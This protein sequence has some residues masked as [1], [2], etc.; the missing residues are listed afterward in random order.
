MKKTFVFLLSLLTLVSCYDDGALREQMQ[1][2]E[3]RLADLEG[4][5]ISSINDQIAGI[6]ESID[7]LRN[8]DSKLK[9]YIDDLEDLAGEL[10]DRIASAEA[11]V[12][13]LE[14]D[15]ASVI[16]AI[17]EL[18]AYDRSLDDK[19][20]LLQ[21]YVDESLKASKDWAAATFA[22]LE[23]YESVQG[24]LAELRESLGR[25][26][27]GVESLESEFLQELADAISASESGMKTW[28]NE[29]LAGSYYDITEVDARLSALEAAYKD[30]DAS[31]KE[32][33]AAQQKALEQ[34]REELSAEFEKAI[35]DAIRSNEGVL[36]SKIADAV[37]TAQEALQEQ[38]DAI[39]VV[40]ASLEERLAIL[41]SD[42]VG[43]IQSLAYVPEYTDGKV[44]VAEGDGV[45]S[46]K[47]LVAPSRLASSL[48]TLWETDGKVIT[49]GLCYSKNPAT[50][51]ASKELVPLKV[52]S[53]TATSEG[54][55]HLTISVDEENPLS[56]DF[57]EGKISALAYIHITD[58]NND[59][60]SGMIVLEGRKGSA[61]PDH[62]ELPIPGPG[63]PSGVSMTANSYIISEA[64]SY[65]IRT[66]KGNSTESVG[67]VASAEVLWESFGTDEAPEAGDLIASVS[68]FNGRIG[69][70]TGETFRE[71]NAVIAAKDSDGNI[72]W[73][74]HIWMT[75]QP[76]E[77][78]YYNGAGT[79]MDRNLG[80]TSAT[81]G[82][83]GALGLLY[84]WGRKDPFL[85]SSSISEAVEAASTLTWPS[86]VAS[87][88]STG[89]IEYAAAN[90]MTFITNGSGNYD[91]YYTG[92]TT[93]DNTRWAESVSS[94]TMFD[95]CPVGWRVPDGGESGVWSSAKGSSSGFTHTYDSVNEGMNFSGQF[96]AVQAIWYPSSG[97]VSGSDGNRYG[98]G[99]WSV[100]WSSSCVSSYADGL[101]FTNAGSVGTFGNR[102]SRAFGYPVRCM[103]EGS[104]TGS[105]SGDSDNP[106]G[107]EGG[108]GS[109]GSNVDIGT[110]ED[111][112]S[113]L[114][115]ANSYIVTRSG[116]YKFKAYKGNSQDL[117]G[118][119]S[120]VDPVG[121]IAKAEVLW[122]S[123]GTSETPEAGA[124]ITDVAY[125]YPYIGFK[126]ADTFREGNAVIAVKDAS[127]NILWSWHIWM[128]DYPVEQVYYNGA[129][130]M[131]DRNLGSTSATPGDVGALGLLY[132]WGRKDPVLGSSSISEAVVAASTITWPS[133]VASDASTGTIEYAA[134][135]PTTFIFNQG[136]NY[137]WYYTGDITTDGTR[138]VESN[139]SKTIYDP[140]PVGWRVPDGGE[141]GV[142]RVGVGPL[143][144]GFPIESLSLYDSRNIGINF[145]NSLGQEQVIWY[146]LTSNRAHYNGVLRF[147]FWG[148]SWSSSFYSDICEYDCFGFTDEYLWTNLD[149]CGSYGLSVRCMKEGSRSSAPSTPD[150]T[151][152]PT[153]DSDPDTLIDYVDEY[154][155][156]HGVGVKI[157]E[158]V[159]APVN[160]GYH[161]T[162]FKY[163]KLYQWGRKYGQGYSGYYYA[164]QYVEAPDSDSV[165]PEIVTG[166]V[167]LS[168]GQSA[169]NANKFYIVS[170]KPYDWH[171]G[172]DETLWNSGTEDAPVKTDYDPC[173]D[174]WRVP[175]FAELGQLSLNY[176]SWTTNESG[177]N[178]IWTSGSQTYSS[179]APQIFLPAAG[180]RAGNGGGPMG[181]SFLGN[182]CQG[183]YWSSLD[184]LEWLNQ[185][186]ENDLYTPVI[187]SFYYFQDAL[188][189]NISSGH[190]C[191]SA[192]GKSVRCVQE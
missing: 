40:V 48:Q 121:E 132:Q 56:A 60:T 47:F 142:W 33:I 41:E 30:A 64:G 69:F 68:Y 111:I 98:G 53:V 136:G 72:L 63:I 3:D 148:I 19:I 55:L 177:Q 172:S 82:D 54:M 26:E 114:E 78:V 135:N 104:R 125:E 154:G 117:A 122:E 75:D 57:W 34:A 174:G 36:D 180:T 97:T 152:D 130:T 153:P 100:Y 79:M 103:K 124:L 186:N 116:S 15:L 134:A 16:A 179:V 42:L 156:N 160:C 10:E 169:E 58:G 129:G 105:G 73:S 5:K 162:D 170:T 85:G 21:T 65:T 139:Q 128:T 107:S 115:T 137:D 126:T 165:A 184:K 52:T 96:G 191:G 8:V 27:D 66:V 92:D 18:K 23:Q 106:G 9:R 181:R 49:A 178:G 173:P 29:H 81:P 183:Q 120:S 1:A 166:P 182:V 167:S 11:D 171:E 101:I 145:C 7:S 189:V 157:G 158:T 14:S 88:A 159:W 112:A 119:S 71:G 46:L 147:D 38:I 67:A 35:S 50:R 31:L 127:D 61:F 99:S 44:V 94:K 163:G 118:S 87:D 86:P 123:F 133:P 141:D 20:A 62:T 80:A 91:W 146:P 155:I 70:T 83:V 188:Q 168:E 6:T 45:F 22:T 89:T 138:W 43:R 109:Y 131:M 25:I 24:V 59:L 149:Y 93:T 185:E 113:N 90:P 32:N 187:L 108:S 28:V 74:W 17:E 51:A 151:P 144:L 12:A 110:S 192:E 143:P 4:S 190:N 84:Q 164:D 150:P 176:S 140:C 175:T 76:K 77:Q 13:E 102:L 39:G 37:K 95:P 2:F 161:A